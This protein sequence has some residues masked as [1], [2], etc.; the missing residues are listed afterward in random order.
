MLKMG[1]DELNGLNLN[2]VKTL[3]SSEL[4]DSDPQKQVIV[5]FVK[6]YEAKFK[7]TP[8]AE[9]AASYD[10]IHILANALK[11]SGAD[12]LKLRDAIESTKNFVGNTGVFN[13]TPGNHEGLTKDDLV[14]YVIKDHKF[15]VLSLKK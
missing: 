4:P 15:S 5:D 6:R 8:G 9:A 2:G 14:F 10:A 12:R 13:F 3:A 11:V 7:V 1:G